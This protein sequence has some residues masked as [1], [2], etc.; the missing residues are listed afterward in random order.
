MDQTDVF[1]SAVIDNG[2]EVLIHT[3]WKTGFAACKLA[4]RTTA[5]D[6]AQ[7]IWNAIERVLKA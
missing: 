6:L 7:P 5:S 2:Q 1:F 4:I 3:T